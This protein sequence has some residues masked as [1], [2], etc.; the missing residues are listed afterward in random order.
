MRKKERK[1][2]RKSQQFTI[3]TYWT[4]DGSRATQIA[5]LHVAS[6]DRM[7]RQLLSHRPVQVLEIAR[8]NSLRFLLCCRHPNLANEQTRERFQS[9]KS[10]N[11]SN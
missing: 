6:S 8:E 4:T 7:V 2:E 1:K 3:K 10:H 11:N 5:S 9:H